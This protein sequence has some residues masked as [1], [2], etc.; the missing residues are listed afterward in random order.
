MVRKGMQVRFFVFFL[1]N[2]QN[3]P[4][5][6]NNKVF[7]RHISNSSLPRFT[8]DFNFSSNFF[9]QQIPFL[10]PTLLQKW[11]KNSEEVIFFCNPLQQ[12]FVHAQCQWF[13]VFPKISPIFRISPPK[14]SDN[15]TPYPCLQ[16]GQRI[17]WTYG[18]EYEQYVAPILLKKNWLHHPQAQ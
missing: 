11:G 13:L 18:N 4:S 7:H 8:W 15:N 17:W 10:T 9:G 2:L 14:N 5:K 16:S 6:K 3:L 1:Q 12:K